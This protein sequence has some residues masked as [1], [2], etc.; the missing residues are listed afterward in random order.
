MVGVST[1]PLQLASALGTPVAST[2]AVIPSETPGCW[3]QH[4]LCLHRNIFLTDGSRV[5]SAEAARHELFDRRR[6]VGLEQA[7]QLRVL[8]NSTDELF[9]VAQILHDRTVDV[10]GWRVPIQEPFPDRDIPNQFSMP[11]RQ[12]KSV[13]VVEFP[14]LA[15]AAYAA[16]GVG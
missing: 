7:N 13:P 15:L 6:L 5:P 10:T 3:N 8:E 16:R 11:V 4:D 1:G 14:D 2:N 9:Q 12:T